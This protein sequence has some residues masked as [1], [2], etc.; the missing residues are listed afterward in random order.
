[1]IKHLKHWTDHQLSVCCD[2]LQLTAQ[3]GLGSLFY[4]PSIR[5]SVRRE[6][7]QWRLMCCLVSA[8]RGRLRSGRSQTVS[9]ASHSP[10]CVLQPGGFRLNPAEL[11]WTAGRC[12]E[13]WPSV[14]PVDVTKHGWARWN[15]IHVWGKSTRKVMS[16]LTWCCG[17]FAGLFLIWISLR[18]D[19][20]NSNQ[21]VAAEGTE[22]WT[23]CR[24]ACRQPGG[25]QH[26]GQLCV[27]HREDLPD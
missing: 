16:F 18:N 25:D 8:T 24:A 13:V 10:I 12:C 17:N 1:M 4:M 22:Q 21:E 2:Q 7:L 20:Q 15:S 19:V 11:C 6:A 27:L 5:H 3:V 14:L 23:C 26:P 9:T